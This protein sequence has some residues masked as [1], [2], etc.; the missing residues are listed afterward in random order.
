M[1]ETGID[2]VHDGDL[3]IDDGIGV[4]R[5]AVGDVILPLEQINLVVVD[6]E[7]ENGFRDLL[8]HSKAPLLKIQS[9]GHSA[10]NAEMCQYG[11]RTSHDE[12]IEDR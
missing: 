5:H 1:G 3:F 4:I 7:I 2:R 8:I 12:K 6:A 11:K 10:E 9:Y